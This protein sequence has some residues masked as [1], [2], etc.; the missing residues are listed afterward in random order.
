[1]FEIKQ[2]EL[3]RP[4]EHYLHCESAR[5]EE[6]KRQREYLKKIAAENFSNLMKVMTIRIQDV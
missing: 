2:T 4:F 3:K 5:R 6:R 1:M